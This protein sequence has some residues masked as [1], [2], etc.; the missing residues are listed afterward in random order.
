[1][2][3]G[4]W[5]FQR[6]IVNGLVRYR[7]WSEDTISC[8]HRVPKRSKI[9]QHCFASSRC[10]LCSSTQPYLPA[11]QCAAHVARVC[12]NFLTTNNIYPL[13]WSPYSPDL[14]A[15]EHLCDE[16]DRK[17]RR[18]VHPPRNTVE[19][20]GALTEEWNNIP[21]ITINRLINSIHRIFVMNSILTFCPKWNDNH[22]GTDNIV[23]IV[24]I[25]GLKQRGETRPLNGSP[26]CVTRIFYVIEFKIICI[27]YI[28]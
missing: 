18:G 8:Y 24:C 4:A 15:I 3:Y 6:W 28:Q 23:N 20:T 11:R 7:K 26:S 9:P 14:S 22:N 21:M 5:P 16:L 2:R 25:H 17:V 19:L 13:E 27:L 1:M 12:H 10:S